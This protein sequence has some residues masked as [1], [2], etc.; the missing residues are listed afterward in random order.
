MTATSAPL[1]PP[2]SAD[3]AAELAARYGLRQV[4]VRPSLRQYV[5]ETWVRRD[6][7][8]YL[9]TSRAY[10]ENQDTYLGQLWS[11]LNPALNAAV[12]VLLF[13]FLLDTKRGMNDV[14]AFI[15]VGTFLY[16]FFQ[17]CVNGG[18]NSIAKNLSLVRALHFPRAILPISN[19]MANLTSLVPSL[20]VMAAFILLSYFIPGT[21]WGG[22]SWRWVLIVPAIGLL[23][24]FSL[25]VAFIVARLVAQLPDLQNI[26]GFVLRLGMYASGVIFSIERYVGALNND[27]L[28]H[29]MS[30]QPV[31][32]Y[33]DIARQSLLDEP[34]IPLD[35]TKWVWGAGWAVV[36]LV[37]GF[38]YFWRA[39]ARYGRE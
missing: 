23:Y 16:K 32:I 12:Y 3:E 11:V 19:V 1:P 17:D 30:Y 22:V 27:A 2:S 29:V 26:L 15:V 28:L 20:G 7:A 34:A 31:A 36:F 37:L 10:A 39:E 5:R 9:A 14:V 8:R 18:A 25:G 21:I 33:L 24:V 35:W 6:F 13:G 38:V 4:G